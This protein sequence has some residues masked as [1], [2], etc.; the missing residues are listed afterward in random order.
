VG[1]GLPLAEAAKETD[2]PAHTALFVGFELTTGTALTVTVAFP[3]P[4][5][6]QFASLTLVTL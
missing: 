4:A 1:F 5:L 3:E 6:E 2:P